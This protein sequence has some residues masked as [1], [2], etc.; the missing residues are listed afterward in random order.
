MSDY[1]LIPPGRKRRMA[2]ANRQT[3]NQN[4]RP[5]L[6]PLRLTY[7]HD[8]TYEYLSTFEPIKIGLI[9]KAL[10]EK[11]TISNNTDVSFCTICQ[12]HIY[13][14]IIRRLWCNHSFHIDCID[15]WLTD[16]KCC[17]T[18]KQEQDP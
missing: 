10:V 17:P 3:S 5:V 13:L 9:S 2:Y 8:L 12:H 18:C 4:E 7:E 6:Q 16:N 15:K 11:T 1:R 14:D